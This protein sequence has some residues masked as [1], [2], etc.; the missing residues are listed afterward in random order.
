MVN[1]DVLNKK[2][3]LT[4]VLFSFLIKFTIKAEKH[5]T[6]RQKRE[7]MR[8]R[9]KKSFVIDGSFIAFD[10]DGTLTTIKHRSSWQSVHEYF[11]TWEDEGQIALRDF[12][13]GKISYYD[14]CVADAHSWINRSE[15][16]YQQALNTIEI[17]EGLPELI[18]FLKTKKCI[19]VIISM[20]LSDIVERV[21]REFNFDFWIANDVVRKKGRITGEVV[22]N[23]GVNDKGRILK[24]KLQDYD[25][26]FQKSL[27]IGDSSADIEMF[28]SAYTSIAIEPSTEKVAD[29][30]DFV[31]HSANLKAIIPIL[32][33]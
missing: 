5:F 22:V 26:P 6:F 11:D 9:S 28:Q 7:N 24:S 32:E 23:V 18:E 15:E 27:A 10:F 8:S 33:K 3:L 1:I 19:L 13:D 4:T 25:L 2:F 20:G 29:Q 30:A 16:E 31:C 14:F 21:A 12:L 17:R